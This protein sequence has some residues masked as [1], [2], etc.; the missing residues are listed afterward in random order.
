MV[1]FARNVGGGWLVRRVVRRIVC[2]W[3]SQEGTNVKVSHI[4][5]KKKK[6]EKERT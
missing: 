5:K 3:E 2:G 6:M 1:S 4:N